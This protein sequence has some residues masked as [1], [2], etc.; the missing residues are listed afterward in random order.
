MHFHKIITYFIHLRVRTHLLLSTFI[1][2]DDEFESDTKFGNDVKETD[3]S[4]GAF[5]KGK[6]EELVEEDFNTVADKTGDFWDGSRLLYF[7]KLSIN[8]SYL[9]YVGTT[10]LGLISDNTQDTK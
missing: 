5:Q 9:P 4:N 3:V 8:R 2:I 10:K 7:N 6:N 1:F